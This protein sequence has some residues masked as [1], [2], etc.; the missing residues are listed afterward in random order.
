VTYFLGRETLL[1]GKRKD[2]YRWRKRLFI[3]M[4]R[5]AQPVTGF[6][7]IPPNQVVE[8]GTQVEL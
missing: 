2:M 7:E 5:N 1:L 4:S 3:A 6:F 8:V